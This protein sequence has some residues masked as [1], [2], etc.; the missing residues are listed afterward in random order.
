MDASAHLDIL[1]EG[2][3]PF[4]RF[5]SRGDVKDRVDIPGPRGG[6]DGT[7]IA[8][9]RDVMVGGGARFIP[10][11]GG[12]GSGKTHAYWALKDKETSGSDWTVVYIPS[13]PTAVRILLHVYTCIT[14]EIPW[15]VDT[16]AVNL[17]RKVAPACKEGAHGW[18]EIDEIAMRAATAYPEAFS[19]CIKALLACA[20]AGD[21]K[22]RN[23]ARRWILGEAIDEKEA[24]RLGIHSVIEEDDTCLAMMSL[25]AEFLGKAVV[26]FFDEFESP[27]RTS[28]PEAE[29]KFIETL[30]LVFDRV[31]RVVFVGAVLKDIWPR[32]L[33]VAGGGFVGI[34]DPPIE[35]Q[36]FTMGD[37]LSWFLQCQ[38]AFWRE[39]RMEPP[40]DPTFP[41]NEAVL[42][43]V[44]QRAGGNPR[45]TIKLTRVFVEKVVAGEL[46]LDEFGPGRDAGGVDAGTTGARGP[47]LDD[48]STREIDG[49]IDREGLVFDVSSAS[50]TAAVMKGIQEIAWM[51]HPEEDSPETIYEHAF[52]VDGK[53]RK[54]GALVTIG[55]EKVGFDLPSVKTFDRSGGVAAYYCAK[56][57]A[58]GIQAGEFH[59]AVIVMPEATAGDKL[60]FLLDGGT[61]ISVVRLDQARAEMLVQTA[62][63]PE[64]HLGDDIYNIA[65]VIT[66]WNVGR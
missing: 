62:L 54:I 36:P 27:Y 65:A 46:S 64:M 40:G 10:V 32:V 24:D 2:I 43:H 3:T 35:L 29:A 38:E 21:K 15:F 31:P 66:G 44:H 14:N 55:T 28:G 22:S 11:L 16:V 50:M 45:E 48:A 58:D 60:S 9:A 20:M 23:L 39:R 42:C 19:G 4:D 56:R 59:R 7:I 49:I 34:M 13:P 18:H 5:V 33:E 30:Q 6:M 51:E 63:N 61:P 53:E 25:I 26:L 12:A 1:K 17:L 37:I 47:S 57:L 41:L 8:A 52:T